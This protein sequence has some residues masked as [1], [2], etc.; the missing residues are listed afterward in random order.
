MN[1]VNIAV[2]EASTEAGAWCEVLKA[3]GHRVHRFSQVERFLKT[4]RYEHFDLIL[5]DWEL[6][7]PRCAADVLAR[8]RQGLGLET[9]IL[10]ATT[11]GEQVQL[12]E[13]LG[14]GADDFL[15]KPVRHAELLGRVEALLLRRGNPV[16]QWGEER[17]GPYLFNPIYSSVQIGE[18]SIALTPKELALSLLLFRNLDKALSRSQIQMIVWGQDGDLVS[19]RTM[20]AHLSRLRGKLGLNKPESEF[21]LMP[22]YN[23]GY[24]LVRLIQQEMSLAS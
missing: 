10:V 6:Q 4:L 9:P 22:I 23:F 5:L 8:V 14:M 1:V 17:Y 7:K 2:V 20:D 11:L 24:R 19:T 18:H 15:V 16:L 12:H 13:L 21:Q 3:S